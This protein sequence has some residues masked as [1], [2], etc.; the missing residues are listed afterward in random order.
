[1]SGAKEVSPENP[2][3]RPQAIFRGVHRLELDSPSSYGILVGELHGLVMEA[4]TATESLFNSRV[5]K[6]W[7]RKE[8]VGRSQK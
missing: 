7:V 4:S 2:S 3:A 1:M 6:S 8:R 5:P